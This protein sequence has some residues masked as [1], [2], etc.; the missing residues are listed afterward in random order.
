MSRRDGGPALTK[1]VRRELDDAFR[2]APAQ[3]SVLDAGCGRVS[4]LRLYRDR[5]G[6][7][8]G[9]DIHPPAPGA[10]P[11]L[12]EFVAADLCT[13]VSAFPA[14]SFDVV[15][16]SFT[17]EHFADPAAAFANMRRWLRPAG[18]LVLTT[19][20]RRHPFVWVY[21]ALPAGLRAGA[22]RL[23][24][25]TA[26][27]AHPLVGSCNSPAELSRALIRA[28]FTDV[29]ITTVGHLERAWGR[30]F[31]GRLLGRVGDLIAQP[32]PGRRSTIVVGAR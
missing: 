21:L 17:V 3:A 1:V 14:A 4:A 5:I 30:W 2:A 18:R 15:L 29:R 20:N 27:D 9:A 6:R 22:Q 26:A 19:V 7:F 16:S 31:P 11:H 25:A 32:F 28:G 10:L 13:D 12:D 24:K 23:V 8:V